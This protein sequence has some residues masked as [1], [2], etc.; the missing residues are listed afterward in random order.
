[1]TLLSDKRNRHLSFSPSF[2][3]YLIQQNSNIT[4][5]ILRTPGG[6]YL[7]EK[8]S[9]LHM[10]GFLQREE[11]GTRVAGVSPYFKMLLPCV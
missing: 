3:H 5:T 2:L 11:P 7:R 4:K 10:S 8:F 1:M 6:V 9:T